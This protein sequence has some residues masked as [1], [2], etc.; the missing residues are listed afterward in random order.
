MNVGDIINE[1][2][3]CIAIFWQ[4]LVS[5]RVGFKIPLDTYSYNPTP[6]TGHIT[7]RLCYVT[8]NL[9]LMLVIKPM[10]TVLSDLCLVLEIL[11]NLSC[12]EVPDLDEAIN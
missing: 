9:L 10:S 8:N 7:I 1:P 5:E 11:T 4:P 12:R 2:Y 6:C 3:I